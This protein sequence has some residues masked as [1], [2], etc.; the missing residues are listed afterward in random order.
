MPI[1]LSCETLTIQTVMHT[2]LLECK[3]NK[4]RKTKKNIENK[5]IFTKLKK[6]KQNKF[7]ENKSEL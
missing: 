1:R 3:R 5:N 4:I 2:I 6:P 7:E